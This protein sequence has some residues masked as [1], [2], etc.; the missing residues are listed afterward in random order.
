MWNTNPI[1][2]VIQ[3][4]VIIIL[5]AVSFQQC[6]ELK[7]RKYCSAAKS[8]LANLAVAQEAYFVDH[9]KFVVK[10]DGSNLSK[11]GFKKSPD[12]TIKLSSGG[13][14]KTPDGAVEYFIAHAS[15]KG[16]DIDDDGKPDIFVWHSAK[17]GLQSDVE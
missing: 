7:K 13:V 11:G 8:D 4:L 1:F 5:G 9:K 12:V 15:H 16:C 3:L 17:G 10:G 2:Y 14:V 6:G